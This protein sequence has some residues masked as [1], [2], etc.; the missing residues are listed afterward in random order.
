M[1][2]RNQRMIYAQ[3]HRYPPLVRDSTADPDV[4]KTRQLAE[5]IRSLYTRKLPER[6]DQLET[7][8]AHVRP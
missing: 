1:D 7:C 5:K 3:G 2:R 8:S 6:I 4:H